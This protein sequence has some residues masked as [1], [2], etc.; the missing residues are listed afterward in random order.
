MDK[1]LITASV[2][3]KFCL[4]S[5]DRITLQSKV[6]ESHVS[7]VRFVAKGK[8]KGTIIAPR[9]VNQNVV[10]AYNLSDVTK[11]QNDTFHEFRIETPKR[12][13]RAEATERAN[14]DFPS[15]YGS[16]SASVESQFV[17]SR[18]RVS[19]FTIVR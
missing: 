7:D 17:F 1:S 15:Y 2:D 11:A 10:F 3:P 16:L 14:N 12:L 6:L 8:Q 19:Y 9:L 5:I 13:V 18:A 4:Q